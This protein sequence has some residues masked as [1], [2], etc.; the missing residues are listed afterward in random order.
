VEVL[1]NALEP[2]SASDDQDAAVHLPLHLFRRTQF[3]ALPDGGVDG[4]QEAGGVDGQ[5]EAGVVSGRG[6]RVGAALC[7][8]A[9][10]R[11]CESVQRVIYG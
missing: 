4:Q 2:E 7:A 10:S 11:F 3:D 1:G 8:A 9:W 5:Q 6:V